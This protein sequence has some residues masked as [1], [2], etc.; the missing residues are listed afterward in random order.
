MVIR[1]MSELRAGSMRKFVNN[2]YTKLRED[3]ELMRLLHYKPAD[4]YK[5]RLDPLDKSLPDIV[6][7]SEKYWDLVENLIIT[8][9]K[10]SD[11]Q[12]EGICRIYLYLGRRRSRFGNYLLADQEIV[13]DVFV[14]EQ[15]NR[16]DRLNWICDKVNA[17]LALERIMGIGKLE[18]A[19]GNPRQA[20]IGYSKYE[21]VYTFAES[22]K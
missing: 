13:V 8:G 6:D 3:E 1:K 22:K 5:G 15:F 9:T 12:E 18:F 10:S 2:I 7:D 19:A 17:L 14:S 16:D 21:L 4:Y 20:P 11:I